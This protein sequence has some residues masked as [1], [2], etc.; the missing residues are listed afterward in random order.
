MDDASA[1]VS[2]LFHLFIAL[3]ILAIVMGKSE[4][5]GKEW[6][7]HVTVLTV[8]PLYRRLG[9]A[10]RLMQRLEETSEQYHQLPRVLTYIKG[11]DV[12]C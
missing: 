8:S 2:V 5:E 9:M 3:T 11:Q 4:G 1:M 7:G 12:F 6:H 10:N